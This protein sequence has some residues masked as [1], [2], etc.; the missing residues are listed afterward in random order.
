MHAL[1]NAL[2]VYI[3]AI[4]TSIVLIFL[5]HPSTSYSYTISTKLYIIIYTELHDLFIHT[6]QNLSAIGVVTTEE[7]VAHQMCASVL[8]DGLGVLAQKVRKYVK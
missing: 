6:I 5:F 3:A 4:F 7:H 1:Y 2:F 8:Q